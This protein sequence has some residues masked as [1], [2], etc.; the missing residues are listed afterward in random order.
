MLI[1]F[2]IAAVSLRASLGS[3]EMLDW[4]S[5][6]SDPAFGAVPASPAV[7][8][9]ACSPSGSFAIPKMCSH[10]KSEDVKVDG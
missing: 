5:V 6:C 1:C 3:V 7:E 9:K 10:E 8:G 2:L 4:A